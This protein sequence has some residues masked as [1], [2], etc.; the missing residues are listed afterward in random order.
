MNVVCMYVYIYYHPFECG[1]EKR[2]LE[3]TIFWDGGNIVR[4]RIPGLLETNMRLKFQV[5]ISS[6]KKPISF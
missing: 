2:G 4:V 6:F 3:R 1:R 5:P